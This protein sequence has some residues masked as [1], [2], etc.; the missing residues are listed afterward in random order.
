[1]VAL[2]FEIMALYF[3]CLDA[4]P[5]FHCFVSVDVQDLPKTKYQI[6]QCN[7]NTNGINETYGSEE[8][9]GHDTKNMNNGYATSAAAKQQYN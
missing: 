4:W 2:I 9:Q 7:V 5:Q 6:A 1:M 3:P 8:L